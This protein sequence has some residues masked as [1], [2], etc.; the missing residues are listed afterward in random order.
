MTRV[1][2]LICITALLG[3]CMIVPLDYGYRGGGYER[4]DNHHDRGDRS[5]NWR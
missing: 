5:R 3:G 4:G 2:T 1:I